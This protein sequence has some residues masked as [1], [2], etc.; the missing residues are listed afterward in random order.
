MLSLN[1]SGFSALHVVATEPDI[2]IYHMFDNSF[3]KLEVA[4]MAFWRPF[5]NATISKHPKTVIVYDLFH[6]ARILNRKVEDERRAYQNTLS[7][8][9]RKE[10][11]M[12]LKHF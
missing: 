5:E 9:D 7:D 4:S 10:L 2:K 6:L 11:I 8:E 12:L 3:H 1:S